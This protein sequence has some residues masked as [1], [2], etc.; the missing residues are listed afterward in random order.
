[1]NVLVDALDATL[2]S[3]TGVPIDDMLDPS[4]GP[5]GLS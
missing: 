1:M 2:A 3:A 4:S 5:K